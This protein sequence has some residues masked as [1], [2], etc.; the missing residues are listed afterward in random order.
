[1]IIFLLVPC[2]TAECKSLPLETVIGVRGKVVLRPEGQSN[3]VTKINKA[4]S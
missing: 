2:Q 1:M 3:K 4:I